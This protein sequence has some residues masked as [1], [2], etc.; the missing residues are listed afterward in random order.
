VSRIS[1][2]CLAFSVSRVVFAC[3][4]GPD[5]SNGHTF[6]EDRRRVSAGTR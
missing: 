6:G 1:V 4:S 2:S 3:A 5:V